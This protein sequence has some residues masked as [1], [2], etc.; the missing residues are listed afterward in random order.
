[1]I[2]LLLHSFLIQQA[3][4]ACK[5][6]GTVGHF[7][8]R[9]EVMCAF[10][11]DYIKTKCFN[12]LQHYRLDDINS[13]RSNIKQHYNLPHQALS[14]SSAMMANKIT[15]LVAAL[16]AAAAIVGGAWL[17]IRDDT[18]PPDE[19]V[20][21]MAGKAIVKASLLTGFS[22]RQRVSLLCLHVPAREL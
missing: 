20:S 15:A 2:S 12:S 8:E 4:L 5:S 7:V 21:G 13:V 17:P 22:S 14:T 6:H 10:R 3:S 18:T 9:M 16:L 1:M 11:R 19:V